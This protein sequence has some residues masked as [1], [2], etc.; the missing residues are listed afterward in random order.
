MTFW[1]I[2]F[3]FTS[4]LKV[5]FLPLLL[6]G[7]EVA[8]LIHQRQDVFPISVLDQVNGCRILSD[9]PE[10]GVVQTKDGTN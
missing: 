4:L 1:V 8:S 6:Q 5:D 3:F 2:C 7:L 9:L 10:M